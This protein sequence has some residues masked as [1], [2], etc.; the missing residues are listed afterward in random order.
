[1]LSVSWLTSTSSIS[2]PSKELFILEISTLWQYPQI[3]PVVGV[4][5]KQHVFFFPTV[6]IHNNNRKMN[7]IF[8]PGNSPPLESVFNTSLYHLMSQWYFN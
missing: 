7:R 8:S 4:F 3:F 6:D 1:M 2:T 5:R